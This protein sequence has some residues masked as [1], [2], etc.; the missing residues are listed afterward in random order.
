MNRR[1]RYE[2]ERARA[3]DLPA[4][5][6]AAADY[7]RGALRANQPLVDDVDGQRIRRLLTELAATADGLYQRAAT[8]AA[9]EGNT[10]RSRRRAA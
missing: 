9:K 7:L 2:I 1:E 8:Q 6:V 10:S 3:A 5:V 4:E